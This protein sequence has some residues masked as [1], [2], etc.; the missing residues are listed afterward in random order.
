MDNELK[1]YLLQ[2]IKNQTRILTQL[3]RIQDTLQPELVED[4][5]LEKQLDEIYER[6][7]D[8]KF[9]VNIAEINL[10]EAKINA[11]EY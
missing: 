6:I 10:F 2:I 4:D 9:R 7:S 3:T 11:G 8:S 1:S 5:N